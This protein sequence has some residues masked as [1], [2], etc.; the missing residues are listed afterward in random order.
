VS[1]PKESQRRILVTGAEVWLVGGISLLGFWFS[2]Y[3]FGMGNHFEQVPGIMRWMDPRL[4]L[5]DFE[6][7]AATAYGGRTFYYLLMSGLARGIGLWQSFLLVA[8]AVWI[9]YAFSAWNLARRT[10]ELSAAQSYPILV[11]F[12]A[13]APFVLGSTSGWQGPT[14]IPGSVVWPFMLA[15][16][17]CSIQRQW[18]RFL[19]WGAVA[20]LFQ[21]LLVAGF[22]AI[23]TVSGSMREFMISRESKLSRGW[24]PLLP[25]VV[26]AAFGALY[27]ALWLAPLLGSSPPMPGLGAILVERAPQH[28]SP[29]FFWRTEIVGL[30]SAFVAF[31][32]ATVDLRR[33]PADLGRDFYRLCWSAMLVTTIVWIAGVVGVEA[34]HNSFVT[35]A[36][37]F[38]FCFIPS[39]FGTILIG[40]LVGARLEKGEFTAVIGAG[41]ALCGYL[42]A[43]G[44]LVLLAVLILVVGPGR[45]LPRTLFSQLLTGLLA[46]V[47]IAVWCESAWKR[48]WV[49]FA[50]LG[51][52]CAIARV[53]TRRGW[54]T[55]V[56]AAAASAVSITLALAAGRNWPLFPPTSLRIQ[57]H[58]DPLDGVAEYARTHSD[59]DGLFLTPPRGERFRLV[60]ERAIVVGALGYPNRPELFIEWRRRMHDCYKSAQTMQE[61]TLD[62]Q[63][64]SISDGEILRLAKE[65]KF[66]GAVLFHDTVTQLPI[67]YKDRAYKLVALPH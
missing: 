15:M 22:V 17:S 58:R 36:Q 12:V 28:Y 14:L 21:P 60:A 55:G 11:L 33:I 24:S 42:L 9:A 4:F 35:A 16:L 67:L 59:R 52:S 27:G 66:E 38:R 40:R 64:H 49:L 19:L 32:L 57:D 25:L 61:S 8:M 45:L 18:W 65:Y 43:N 3:Q 30:V 2:V 63:Y 5:S 37:V 48:H 46:V 13:G 39:W 56:F 20:V 44:A 6:M 34:L 7:R 47:G 54:M 29:S 31:G 53:A 10:L 26:L 41:L 51:T 1:I 62:A 23:M 50:V